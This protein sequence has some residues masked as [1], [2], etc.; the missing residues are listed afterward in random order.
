M[1]DTLEKL[2]ARAGTRPRRPLDVDD[3]ICRGRRLRR[4]RV[5][6]AGAGGACLLLLVAA[7]SLTLPSNQQPAPYVGSSPSERAIAEPDEEGDDMVI[8]GGSDDPAELGLPTTVEPRPQPEFADNEVLVFGAGG[9]EVMR[10][11]VDVAE[12]TVETETLREGPPRVDETAITE[13]LVVTTGLTSAGVVTLDPYDVRPLAAISFEGIDQE[14]FYSGAVVALGEGR[15]LASGSEGGQFRL[16]EVDVTTGEVTPHELDGLDDATGPMCT[17]TNGQIA[18][19]TSA[20][21]ALIDHTDLTSIEMIEGATGSRIACHGTQVLLGSLHRPEVARIDAT[22]HSELPAWELGTAAATE[23][24]A[25]IGE[26]ALVVDADRMLWRCAEQG[27]ETVT[28]LDGSPRTAAGIGDSAV[29]LPYYDS[30]TIDVLLLESG[31]RI[32]TV[33]G[34]AYPEATLPAAIN[35]E[36][37]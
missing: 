13:G 2:V 9:P 17:T 37:R 6:L 20:G 29:V 31:R 30:G 8:S 32:A 23:V 33:E 21:L 12:R 27:C 4:R 24:F 25:N 14:L 1:P 36:A 3:V 5:V 10:L 19:T 22:D 15:V 35:T 34:P 28:E 18:V 16:F 26:A 11:R 7:V